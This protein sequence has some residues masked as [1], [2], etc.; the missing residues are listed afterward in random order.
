MA[1]P[2]PQSATGH[3]LLDES[4]KTLALICHLHLAFRHHRLPPSSNHPPRA[5][6]TLPRRM[7]VADHALLNAVVTLRKSTNPVGD[8]LVLL[9]FAESTITL[10]CPLEVIL[11]L[12]LLPDQVPPEHAPG[13]NG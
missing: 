8:E 9:F 3:H 4:V 7:E 13:R 10:A 5:G 11:A 2:A 6:R 12:D 1:G